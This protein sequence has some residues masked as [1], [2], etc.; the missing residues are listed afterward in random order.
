MRR[1]FLDAFLLVCSLGAA[2]AVLGALLSQYLWACIAAAIETFS[3][4]VAQWIL[5]SQCVSVPAKKFFRCAGLKPGEIKCK[6]GLKLP[7][8]RKLN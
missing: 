6:P 5:M 4:C 2:A 3:Q 1:L 7:K 8:K